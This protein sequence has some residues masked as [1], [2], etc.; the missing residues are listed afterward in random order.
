MSTILDN[1][2]NLFKNKDNHTLRIVSGGGYVH[3]FDISEHKFGETAFLN[4]AEILTD[5]FA[6]V[7]FTQVGVTTTTAKFNAWRE[8]AYRNG[9]R[10][11]LQMY[12]DKGYAVIGYDSNID[13]DGK[14]FYRFYELREKDYTK[15]TLQDGR[16]VIE[17]KD[18]TQHFYVI[19]T[20]T[21]EAVG[22]S[23]Y[24]LCKPYISLLDN[25]LNGICTSAERLG[26]Y[27]VASPAS[28]NFGGVLTR[29]EKEEIE[30]DLAKEYGMLSHQKQIMMLGRPMNM[31]VVSLASLDVKMNEKVRT[32]ILAIADRLKV[33]CNQI[34]MIDGGSSKA[35]ANGTEYREGDLAKY[36]Q[37]RR[38]LNAT[39]YDMA[40]E[41]GMQVDYT[42]EN[43]PLTQQN[44]TI[45][46]R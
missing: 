14:V 17:C 7:E 16:E 36:R 35:F 32:A 31:N 28:D 29:T 9:Q 37:F 24:E 10:I 30:K 46:Q 27:V 5:I 38:V 43:E 25:I 6:E 2:R 44:Q 18:A 13:T 39:F 22:K 20:P 1:I 3:P 21:F 8:W 42:I 26:A 19:K 41:L 11:L 40:R 15:R 33:P 12:R 4:I 23:D 45:E 34:A